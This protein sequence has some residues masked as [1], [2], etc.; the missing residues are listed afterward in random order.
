MKTAIFLLFYTVIVVT[1]SMGK[2][3]WN[4]NTFQVE[5]WRYVTALSITF[6]SALRLLVILSITSS[7]FTALENIFFQFRSIKVIA[8]T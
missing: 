7:Y 8:P 6:T 3:F 1:D 5:I 4:F 2:Y